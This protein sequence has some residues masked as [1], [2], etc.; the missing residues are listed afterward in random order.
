[1]LRAAYELFCERGYQPASM[2]AIA[3]RAGVAVQT[4]H[5]TFHTKGRLLNEVVWVYSAGEPEPRPVMERPWMVEALATRDPRRILALVMEHGTDIYARVAPLEPAVLAASFVD[6][7]VADAWSAHSQGRRRGMRQF[8]E[9]IDSR[10]DLAP[11]LTVDR[12][13]DIVFTIHSHEVFLG[14]T[15]GC[16]WSLPEYKAWQYEN[17]CHHVLGD[18]SP[19]A[20]RRAASGL[21]FENL[22][23]QRA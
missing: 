7:E 5:F 20:R 14:L 8:I 23:G 19:A 6:A 18:R 17:L 16:G 4:L 13:T 11:G 21:S 22:V 3:E 12:A 10:G 2:A 1:M 15:A 9:T